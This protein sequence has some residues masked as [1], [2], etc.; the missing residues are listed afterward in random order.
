MKNFSLYRFFLHFLPKTGAINE[1][2]FP[3][4]EAEALS[5]LL[6]RY[7]C[8]GAT[9]CAFDEKGV[10]NFLAFGQA[11][12]GAPTGRD[13]A[14]RIASISKFVTALGAMR[15]WEEGRLSLDRDVNEYLP[16]SLRHPKAPET[17][18]TL[19]MLLSHTAGLHD[20]A[21][22]N[23]GIARGDNL[24]AI[25]AGDS[26]CAH[27]PGT[28]W[29]YSNLGAGVAGVAMEGALQTDFE[30]LMQETVFQP[31]G[32]S[33]TFYP[34]KAQGFLA[35]AYRILPPHKAPNYDAQARQA[36]PLP[37]PCV[38]AERHY[39]LGHANLCVSAPELSRLGMAGMQPGFLRAETLAEMRKIIAPFGRR[40]RDLSQG[41]GVFILQDPSVSPRPLY[42]HQGMAYG[43]VH[44]LFF[45]PVSRRGLTLLTSGASEGREGVLADVNRELLRRFFSGREGSGR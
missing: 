3:A 1:T 44:G 28:R 40:A 25:L 34:A 9:L 42:G 24:S 11:R 21:A 31:L 22:Y 17:P 30:T 19:R 23:G 26:F 20:G 43:A 45:D 2:D 27:L 4:R 6:R 16:F 35:D 5:A 7:R 13:T 12:R 29:E 14:Y 36:R 18:I 33:A 10:T 15:L 8:L 39:A 37:T 38:N 32:V 41:L